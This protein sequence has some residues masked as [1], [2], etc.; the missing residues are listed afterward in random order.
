M[1]KFKLFARNDSLDGDKLACLLLGMVYLEVSQQQRQL[2]RRNV[3][4]GWGIE[5]VRPSSDSKVPLSPT[6]QPPFQ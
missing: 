4:A 5:K 3:C 1:I 2:T 6:N